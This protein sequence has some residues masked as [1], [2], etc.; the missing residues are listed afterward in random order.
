MDEKKDD[1]AID[2]SGIKN[3]VKKIFS[4][5]DHE[6]HH[7]S[8]PGSQVSNPATDASDDVK[9]DFRKVL[10]F[11]S[12][13]NVQLTLLVL[14][15]LILSII[16]RMPAIS[17]PFTDNWAE[18]TLMNQYRSQVEQQV[19]QQYPNLPPERTVEIVEKQVSDGI[20]QNRAGFEQQRDQI[21]KMFKAKLE[22]EHNGKSFPY[23]SDIDPYFWFEYAR[24]ILKFGSLS[25]FYDASGHPI[26][27]KM[28]A[29][30]GKGVDFSIHPY[31]IAWNHKLFTFFSDVPLSYSASFLPVLLIAISIIPTFFIGRRFGGNISGFFAAS[32]MAITV[33]AVGRTMW[34]RVDTDVYNIFFPLFLSWFF[35]EAVVSKKLLWRVI[36]SS[37]T[38]IT[39]GI[40]FVAWSGWWYMFDFLLFSLFM[41][42][43]VSFAGKKIFRLVKSFFSN[44][45]SKDGNFFKSIFHFED[46]P[47]K[48]RVFDLLIVSV[49]FVLFTSLTLG[50]LTG[51]FVHSWTSALLYPL[52]FSQNVKDA[53]HMNLWPNVYTTVAELNPSNWDGVADQ[54]TSVGSD[55]WFLRWAIILS[56]FAGIILSGFHDSREHEWYDIVF[57][58]FLCLWFASTTYAAYKGVRFILLLAPAFSIAWGVGV[59]KGIGILSNFVSS[60]LGVKKVYLKGIGIFIGLLFLILPFQASYATSQNDVPIMNDAWWDALTKIKDNSM[61]NSIITSWWDFGHHFKYVADRA[62]TFDGASQN[63]PQAHWVGLALLTR[64]EHYSAS[65]LQMLD[66]GA[67]NA[68]NIVASEKGDLDAQR[69]IHEI[70]KVDEV[71]AKKILESEGINNVSGVLKNTYCAPPEGFFITSDDMI[72]K[73]GVWGHFG[74]WDYKRAYAWTVLK[75]N[76][77]PVAIAE[78]K[79]KLNYSEEEAKKV[80]FEMQ[81][82]QDENAVNQWIAPWPGY[83]GST[84]CSVDNNTALCGSIKVDLASDTAFVQTPQGVGIAKSLAIIKDGKYEYIESTNSNTDLAVALV[85]VDGSSYYAVLMSAEQGGSIFSRLF[86]FGGHDLKY[87]DFFD[88]QQ[89]I[90]GGKIFT[91]KIDWNGSSE[92]V[93]ND[94]RVRDVVRSGYQV[95]VDYIGALENGTVFDA[96]IPGWQLSDISLDSRFEDFTTVPFTFKANSGAVI[97]GFD[98][99]V[100]GMRAG[101]EKTVTIPPTKAYGLGATDHPLGNKT[102]IFKIKVREIK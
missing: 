66:C 22:F 20:A 97:R 51:S 52:D 62:V 58:I 45:P 35:L 89:Q 9:I 83:F 69:I 26:D 29:P 82:L 94:F 88:E 60:F 3:A 90:T 27:M 49:I 73:G 7:S 70:L 8:N 98:D 19:A 101:E 93:V 38:G 95:S 11:F 81:G 77:S 76:V 53:A 40:F 23:M 6:H 102:L 46:V 86:Y 63:Q 57:A 17:Q 55:R 56:A 39:I 33:S 79:S 65:I 28:L 32:M 5:K 80:Y 91:W 12:N 48:R 14:I 78:M 50:L 61:N 71:E 34:G 15:P 75:N 13:K 1:I 74:A 42:I 100:A 59:G 84:G 16:V 18:Q 43:L 54:M 72:G 41:G 99:A 44:T 47:S 25:Q 85:P 31:L 4:S 24:N 2:V 92:N 67:N 36:F 37:L 10:R 68:Y 87:F 21:S 64:D 30:N 96:N